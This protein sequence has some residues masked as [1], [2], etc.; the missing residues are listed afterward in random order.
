MAA[1]WGAVVLVE[2][3]LVEVARAEVARE[4]AGREAAAEGPMAATAVVMVG[5]AGRTA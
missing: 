4:E 1:A 5:D 2:V 3:V